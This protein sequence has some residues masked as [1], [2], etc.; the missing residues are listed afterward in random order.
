MGLIMG[1]I[2]PS[3]KASENFRYYEFACKCGVCAFTGIHIDQRVIALAQKIRTALGRSLKV[4]SACRCKVHNMAEGGSPYSKHLKASGFVAIDLDI[5]KST[6]RAIA[7]EIAL[8]MGASVIP[9]KT[10]MHFDFRDGP[11]KLIML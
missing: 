9:Y 5:T 11:K 6:E 1:Q 7:T 4:N 3:D 10:F 2:Y 8:A